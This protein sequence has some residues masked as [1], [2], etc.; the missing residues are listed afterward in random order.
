MTTYPRTTRAAVHVPS[1]VRTSARGAALT[2]AARVRSRWG[3]GRRSRAQ[4]W[5]RGRR[6]KALCYEYS[7]LFSACASWPHVRLPRTFK[8]NVM[9]VPTYDKLFSDELFDALI[10]SLI[11]YLFQSFTILS[12]FCN[13]RSALSGVP[14]PIGGALLHIQVRYLFVV[15]FFVL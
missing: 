12:R 7:D 2:R 6:R 11:A 1:A 15:H 10:N 14:S 5:T 4:W 9:T 3:S 13:R 8:S